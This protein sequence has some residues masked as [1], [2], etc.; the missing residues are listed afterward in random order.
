MNIKLLSLVLP[1]HNEQE[2][3]GKTFVAL[4]TFGAQVEVQG[5]QLE[6][7]FVNDGSRDKSPELLDQ[8]AQQDERVTVIHLARNFGHQAAVTAGLDVASG[9]LIAVMDSDLQ[10]PPK[11]LLPMIEKW[12][13][14]YQVVYAVREKRKESWW[15]KSGYW[16]F[17]RMLK[18]MS[19]IDIPL[20]SGDFC[21]MDRS[22]LDLLKQL[23]EKQR[24]VRGLRSWIGL[25]QTGVTYERAA[26][27]AGT[28][29]YR[30]WHLVKLAMDGFVGFSNL[31]LRLVTR[32]GFFGLASAIFLGIWVLS[33]FVYESLSGHRTPRGWAS[34]ACLVLFTSS[35]QLI[36]LG[37]M[38]EYLARI[39][40]EVKQRPT[41]LIAKVVKSQRSGTYQ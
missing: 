10:D 18:M 1:V 6:I 12:R 28:P 14:G 19:E 20:D 17:Y 24:F 39:F 36:S 29:S 34:L 9:D 5:I 2:V 3:I 22:A 35:L 21:L 13:E 26:R 30:L 37:I 23:P 40:V 16:V 15:K 25:K 8:F 11:S 32:I 41:Y 33:S 4:K 27:A 38:G 31:P 7:I